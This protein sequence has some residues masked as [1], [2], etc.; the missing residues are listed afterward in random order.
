[1]EGC[2]IMK[3]NKIVAFLFVSMI[4]LTSAL[5]AQ[6]P[7]TISGKEKGGVV[8]LPEEAYK[9][10]K[11]FTYEVAQG[12]NLHWLAAKFYGDARQWTRIYQANKGQIHNPNRLQIGQKL[13][14]PAGSQKP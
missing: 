1:M 2:L 8:S 4:C 6:V 9:V 10:E 5:H 3:C 12:D 14:I 11:P 13:L 7:Q